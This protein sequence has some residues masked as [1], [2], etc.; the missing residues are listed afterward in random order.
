MRL[1][2]VENISANK[3]TMSDIELWYRRMGHLNE[4]DL[5]KLKNL[6]LGVDFNGKLGQSAV[7]ELCIFGK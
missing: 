6:A 2:D 3:A 5:N 7:C 1:I 4:S